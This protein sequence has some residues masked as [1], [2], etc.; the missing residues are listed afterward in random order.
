MLKY[1]SLW[2]TITKEM[3]KAQYS[4][5]N[6]MPFSIRLHFFPKIKTENTTGY[7]T[8]NDET[9]CNWMLRMPVKQ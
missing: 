1:N 8:G 4:W 7:K 9:P 5:T 6:Y 3:E 2:L